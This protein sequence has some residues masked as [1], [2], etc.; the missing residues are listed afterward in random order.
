MNSFVFQFGNCKK[1]NLIS[2]SILTNLAYIYKTKSISQ[3]I[4]RN[5]SCIIII[6]LPQISDLFCYLRIVI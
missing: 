5:L 4:L 2:E 6:V 3:I 1:S